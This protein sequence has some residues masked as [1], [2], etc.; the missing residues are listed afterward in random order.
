MSFQPAGSTELQMAGVRMVCRV[1]VGR[2]RDPHR[3]G[4]G[5][6]GGGRAAHQAW[7]WTQ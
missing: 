2:R 3:A 1:R 4:G 5:A 7:L 6:R